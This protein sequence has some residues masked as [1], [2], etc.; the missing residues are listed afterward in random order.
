[1]SANRRF[2]QSSLDIYMKLG[3]S[4]VEGWLHPIDARIISALG[5]YQTKAG[6]KGSVGEIGVYKGRLF[7]LLSLLSHEGEPL[8]A[9]DPFTLEAFEDDVVDASHDK[10]IGSINDFKTNLIT[11]AG[12]I[13]E[14]Q[15]FNCSSHMLKAETLLDSA[16]QARLVSIDGNHSA[17]FVY[18]DLCLISEILDENGIIMIDDVFNPLYPDVSVG[19]YKYLYHSDDLKPFCIGQ[20]KV[21]LCR[22][23]ALT[24]F[25]DVLSLD[26]NIVVK[27]KMEY[28]GVEVDIVDYYV[29]T[30]R[31]VF[32][33]LRINL[34]QV[35]GYKSFL[36]RMVH[37]SIEHAIRKSM[38]HLR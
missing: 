3:H 33:F 19:L 4:L 25:R 1:M 26:K 6:I 10:V 24:K 27:T 11:H 28:F 9:I 13:N 15:I 22:Q 31:E 36:L 20:N 32:Y 7:I 37:K 35:Q 38:T 30:Y 16:S 29:N 34:S 23:E 18:S 12:E 8:F 14:L 2:S 17:K 5:E 21:Y